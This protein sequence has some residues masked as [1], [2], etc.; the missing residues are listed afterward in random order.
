MTI[1]ETFARPTVFEPEPPAPPLPALAD[2]VSLH[3]PPAGRRRQ[4]RRFGGDMVRREFLAKTTA[5]IGILAASSVIRVSGA[6][7][8]PPGGGDCT[9]SYDSVIPHS[10]PLKGTP[11]VRRN[12]QGGYASDQDCYPACGPSEPSDGYCLENSGTFPFP[13]RVDGCNNASGK[14]YA[15]RPNA[16]L[17]SAWPQ[18][19]GWIWSP[20]S[21]NSCSSYPCST[22]RYY[23]CMDGWADFGS[24]W[25]ET[26]CRSYKSA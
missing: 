8:A 9:A 22:T 10:D 17:R 4:G 15:R 23:G 18:A 20:A 14:R 3:V 24:G 21:G 6:G 5:A 2:L 19:D 12:S 13:H 7:G 26:I 16:C 25:Y 1:D 11:C